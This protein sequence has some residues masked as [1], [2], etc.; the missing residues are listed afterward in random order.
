MK[1][2]GVLV[3]VGLIALAFIAGAWWQLDR[4]RHSPAKVTM[5]IV[6]RPIFLPSTHG[7]AP[8]GRILPDSAQ[9]EKIDS[10]VLRAAK[11]DSL[12]EAYAGAM[13][14][15]RGEV[16]F[17]LAYD[18]SLGGFRAYGVHAIIFDPIGKLFD[19]TTRYDSASLST[20]I[21]T[22]ETVVSDSWWSLDRIVLVVAL[23]LS[24][25]R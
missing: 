20:T 7:T 17:K 9:Q 22:I 16:P 11:A 18:D 15:K 19:V 2:S 13:E 10:L 4:I 14:K 23:I 1:A 8:A 24:L 6:E 25:L 21:K 12:A 5:Q 3:L